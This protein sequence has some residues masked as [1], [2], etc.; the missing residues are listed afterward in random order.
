MLDELL[1]ALGICEIE[2]IGRN[3]AIYHFNRL[4]PFFWCWIFFVI[5][6]APF[7]A[8]CC[9]DHT[10]QDIILDTLTVILTG[11]FI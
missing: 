9:E 11:K 2:L 10:I 5:I 4:N 7:V 3:S 1:V 8:M 6:T